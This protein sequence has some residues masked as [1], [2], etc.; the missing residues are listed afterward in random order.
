[1]KF[2]SFSRF[3]GAATLLAACGGTAP[4]SASAPAAPGRAAPAGHHGHHHRFDDAERWAKVFDDPARDA[5]QK[6][7]HVVALL[8]LTAGM[9]V[10]DVGAGTGYFEQRLARAV[11]PSGI[12]HALDV[13]PDMVRHLTARM[14]REGVGNVR[15]RVTKPDDPGL[16]DGTVDRVLVVD[17]WHHVE[18]RAGYA[19]RLAASLRPGGE[20]V[21]VDFTQASPHGPPVRARLAPEEVMADLRGAGL[22]AS[23]RPSELPY[24]YV[25]VGA[26]RP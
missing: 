21:I 1:M 2:N 5:W 7:D 26:R 24:Q 17:T 10:V 23:E 3:L 22:E 13:E 6:P 14:E 19:R 12:V 16:A 25:V 20:I 8:G 9:T 4:R 11:G 15:A 18:D